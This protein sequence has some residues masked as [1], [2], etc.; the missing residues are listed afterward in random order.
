MAAK[1]R[2]W[3]TV[4]DGHGSLSIVTA[5]KGTLLLFDIGDVGAFRLQDAHNAD[6]DALEAENA[7]LR[8]FMW[9]NMP[10]ANWGEFLAA[11]EEALGEEEG[12]DGS[13]G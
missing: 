2:R 5:S 11:M 4:G 1:D 13:E 6:I 9:E 7:K 10:W 8:R 3:Q 12:D